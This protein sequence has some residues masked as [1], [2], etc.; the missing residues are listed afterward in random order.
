LQIRFDAHDDLRHDL[1]IKAD[2]AAVKDTLLLR[3]GVERRRQ[4]AGVAII[5]SLDAAQGR[6][7]A[8]VGQ[9]HDIHVVVY[10]LEIAAVCPHIKSAPVGDGRHRNRHVGGERRCDQCADGETSKKQFFHGY[11]PPPIVLPLHAYYVCSR[12]SVANG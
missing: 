8:G 7:V 10:A 11:F 2:L 4:P 5:W 3:G 9:A 1:R 6:R 12:E